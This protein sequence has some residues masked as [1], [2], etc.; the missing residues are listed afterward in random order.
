VP[1]SALDKGNDKGARW[2]S[3]LECHHLILLAKDLAKG[4][5]ESFFAERQHSAKSEPLP[6]VTVTVSKISVVVIRRCDGDF[7]LL[8]ATWHLAKSLP[9]ARQKS[10]RQK[11]VVDVHFIEIFFIECHTRQRLRR[12]FSKLYR[13]LQTRDKIVVSD[14]QTRKDMSSFLL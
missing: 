3:F 2:W 5:M 1:S 11:A 8:R 6:S 7:S 4:P 9:S 13:V 12:V 10:I 14:S